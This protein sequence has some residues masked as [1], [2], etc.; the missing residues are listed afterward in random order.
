VT[1]LRA[2]IA[3]DGLARQGQHVGA[4]LDLQA[5]VGGHLGAQG[6]VGLRVE[7]E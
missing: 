7:A 5:D 6:V 2:L 4:L 1:K 3:A